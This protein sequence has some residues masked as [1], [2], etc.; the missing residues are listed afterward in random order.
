MSKSRLYSSAENGVVANNMSDNFQSIRHDVLF[1][2][3]EEIKS[4]PVN[5]RDGPRNQSSEQA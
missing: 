2:V 5:D 1:E 3:V 4:E